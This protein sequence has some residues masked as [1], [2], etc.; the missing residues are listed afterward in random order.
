MLKQAVDIVNAYLCDGADMQLN[1]PSAN[2]YR[3]GLSNLPVAANMF[4][5][6]CRIVYKSIEVDIFPRFKQSTFAERLAYSFPKLA[7]YTGVHS[8][9]TGV[10]SDMTC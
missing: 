5:P 2:P 8:G 1:L 10:E 6:T 4:D 3:Q 9:V 7:R